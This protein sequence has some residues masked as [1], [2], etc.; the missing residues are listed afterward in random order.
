[1]KSVQEQFSAAELEA[2][3]R[4]TAAAESRT[5]GEVV[6]VVVPHSGTPEA[7]RWKGGALGAVALPLAMALLHE[8]NGWWGF[9][10]GLPVG[11]GFA[12]LA[13]AGAA[14]G[15]LAVAAWPGLARR[16]A[17]PDAL[18][19]RVL[20]RAEAAFLEEEVFRTRDRTGVLILVS[21]YE[22][23]IRIVA[24]SG[25]HSRVPEGTWP[26]LAAD[27]SSAMR[28]GRDGQALAAAVEA[29]GAT[30]AAHDVPRRSDDRDELEDGVRFRE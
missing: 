26:R 2:V 25:I 15:G 18:D 23:R 19:E 29:V 11:L 9:P 21:L 20:R 28:S 24:D 8:A 27:L 14:L 16:L 4:A 1:M 3:R 6:V 30:L 7:E 12:T 17:S 22:H 5:G 10:L 13:L